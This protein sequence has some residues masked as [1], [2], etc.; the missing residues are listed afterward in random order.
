[1]KLP[2]TEYGIGEDIHGNTWLVGKI[3]DRQIGVLVLGKP[4]ADNNREVIQIWTDKKYRRL[5]VA[6]H[7]WKLARVNRLN[8]KHSTN[9]T[10]DG[11]AWVGAISK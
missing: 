7:L 3:G 9:Q 4:D 6:D 2:L 11:K 5:G 10:E 1:M 8:P